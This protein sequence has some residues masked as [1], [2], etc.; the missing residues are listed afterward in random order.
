[1]ANERLR[2]LEDVEKE[3]AM[4]LQCAG[5]LKCRLF[6]QS[7]YNDSPS[8]VSESSGGLKSSFVIDIRSLHPCF[9]MSWWY[10]NNS[11]P[12]KLDVFVV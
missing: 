3:I 12:I 9:K 8:V 1:M 7:R 5:E 6:P 4:I 11:D 10:K 2:A